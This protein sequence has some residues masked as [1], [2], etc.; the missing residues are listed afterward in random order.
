M[1]TMPTSTLGAN[2]KSIPS[3]GP[4]RTERDDGERQQGRD[5]RDH[6]S[7]YVEGLVNVTGN[8]ALL[9]HHLGTVSQG[10]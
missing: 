1:K 8:N 9:E 5:D 6:G 3:I 2:W 4:D 10:L 7:Q